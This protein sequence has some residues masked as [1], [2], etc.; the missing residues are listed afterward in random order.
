QR[1]LE[2]RGD[3]SLVDLDDALRQAFRHDPMDHLG[4]FFV[5]T[6][7]GRERETLATINPI[8]GLE[9]GKDWELAELRLEAG[10]ELTY[11]YDFG[12]WIE[13]VVQ[14]E[15][16]LPPQPGITYPR[17]VRRDAGS[18]KKRAR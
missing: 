13:H 5:C 2:L 18:A 14:V 16:V 10:D 11:V 15:A 6:G 17:Q 3:N 12:D 7:G 9:E 4:G 1:V 8:S